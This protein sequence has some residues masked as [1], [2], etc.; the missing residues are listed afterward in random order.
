MILQ[1]FIIFTFMFS[2]TAPD[3]SV[4]FF[5]HGTYYVFPAEPRLTN[6]KGSDLKEKQLYINNHTGEPTGQNKE[7]TRQRSA[8]QAHLRRESY[9]Y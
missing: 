7:G 5:F 4:T 1:A 6:I 8:M 2:L 3:T 9:N